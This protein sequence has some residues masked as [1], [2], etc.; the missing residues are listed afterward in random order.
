MAST[1]LLDDSRDVGVDSGEPRFTNPAEDDSHTLQ[2]VFVV[3]RPQ[4]RS[5]ARQSGCRS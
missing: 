3:A 1:N 5:L 4:W 2:R